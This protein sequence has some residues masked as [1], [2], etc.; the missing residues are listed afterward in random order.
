MLKKSICMLL[1][2][3][4]LCALF[5]VAGMASDIEAED[6]S[7]DGSLGIL[8]TYISSYNYNL[9][10]NSSGLASSSASVTAYPGT[11]SVRI[12]MYLQRYNSGWSTVQSWSKEA[13]G[14]YVSLATSHYV[15]SGYNYRLLV[16][17]YAYEGSAVESLSKTDEQWY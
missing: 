16:Y 13:S 8:M 12:S 4:L 17:F 14:T 15:T 9:S 5:P 11:D 1:T 3:I 2:L 6:E 7:A 10:I